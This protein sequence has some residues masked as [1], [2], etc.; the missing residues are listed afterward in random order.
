[1]I[2]SDG[3]TRVPHA[4][5]LQTA[6]ASTYGTVSV[7]RDSTVSRQCDAIIL[8]TSNSQLRRSAELDQDHVK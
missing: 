4:Q 7:S 1:M 2:N 8:K 6:Q 3:W 5:K